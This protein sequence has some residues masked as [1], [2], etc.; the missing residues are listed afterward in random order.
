MSRF[1]YQ[2][3]DSSGR[4]F[5]G[6]LEAPSVESA[7]NQ[8]RRQGLFVR[9]LV[10]ANERI[11]NKELPSFGGPRV[12]SQ[13]FMLF[14]RQLATL[15]KGGT[16]I[17]A[18]V[19]TLADQVK[20]KPF[21]SVLHRVADAMNQGQ[22]FSEAAANYPT[23]F[24]QVFVSMAQAGEA[25]GNLDEMLNRLA[26]FYE[27]EHFT[28]EKVKTALA[29][30]AFLAATTVLVVT[31]LMIFVV[32]QFEANFREMEVELP[33]PTR[34][35]I[36]LNTAF[37][38]FWYLGP[39]AAILLY[40]GYRLG[41]RSAE[42]KYALDRWK[43]RLPIFGLFWRHQLIARFSRTFS[44]LAGTGVPMLDILSIT[45]AVVDNEAAA[46]LIRQS[47]E[48]LRRGAS[49]VGPFEGTP[50]FPPMVVQMMKLGEAS[51][52]LDEAMRNTA[53]FYEAQVDS[54]SDR[55]KTMLEPAMILILTGIVGLIVFAVMMPSFSLI[56]QVQ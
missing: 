22:Q 27:K 56:G 48:R 9:R 13:S 11:W 33:L 8:L 41:Y 54:M 19:R 55:L 16:P 7:A 2:A 36:G 25:G 20:G 42:G 45:E 40:F 38:Q 21:Q 49:M 3:M 30:P 14:C 24:P 32:P 39:A 1:V 18:A 12:K 26:V 10:P 37:H 17:T 46:R 50:L 35:L 29:Y 5:R 28:R 51:G 15:Y 44:S 43:L 23:V 4:R 52:S 31:I 34:I 53:E 47:R 6:K